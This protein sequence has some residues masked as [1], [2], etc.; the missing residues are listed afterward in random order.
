MYDFHSFSPL[1]GERFPACRPNL[2]MATP[3]PERMQDRTG[4]VYRY[5]GP[6]MGSALASG[7]IRVFPGHIYAPEGDNH[8]H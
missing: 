1:P 6:M 5:V 8:A 3:V 4:R 7:Q 2:S